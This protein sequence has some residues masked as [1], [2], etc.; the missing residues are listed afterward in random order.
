MSSVAVIGAGN[1]G[2]ASAAYLAYHGVPVHLWN[3]SEATIALLQKNREITCCGVLDGCVPVALITTD[4]EEALRGV[5]LI[6]IT[7]PASSH[8]ELA[9]RMAPHLT[10]D[11]VIVLNPGRTFGALEFS[12]VLRRCGIQEQPV[13]GEAQTI[14]FTCRKKT[15][16]TVSILGLKKGVLVSALGRARPSDILNRLPECL[17]GYFTSAESMVQTSLGNVGMILHTAPTLL[18]VGWIEYPEVDFKYYYN[19]ITP[20]VCRLLERL[21]AERLSVSLVLGWQ[22][23]SLREWLK[24]IYGAADGTLYECVQSVEAYRTIDAPVSINHR[25]LT[26]DVPTGLVPLESVGEAF[27][28]P[29]P[30]ATLL[31]DLAGYLLGRDLRAGGRTLKNL[32]MDHLQLMQALGVN[33]SQ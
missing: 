17:A 25:Y 2:L 10:A 13:I 24:R 5:E 7:T 27:G 11:Q 23:E 3:R 33:L 28:V 19:G 21:D 26:E 1:S 8:A 12:T 15:A 16:A 6:M 4:I 32:G 20:S 18:N 22:V 29:T 9:E 31:I 30:V 14:V